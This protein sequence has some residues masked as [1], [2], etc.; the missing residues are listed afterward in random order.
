MMKISNVSKGEVGVI[1][2]IF[3]KQEEL[4]RIDETKYSQALF[5]NILDKRHAKK[6]TEHM[7]RIDKLEQT[8]GNRVINSI[9]RNTTTVFCCWRRD[10]PCMA[11]NSDGPCQRVQTTSQLSV[12]YL[13]PCG[14]PDHFWVWAFLATVLNSIDFHPEVMN[15]L[16]KC[17]L[18][19]EQVGSQSVLH[20]LW[21]PVL[22]LLPGCVSMCACVGTQVWSFRWEVVAGKRGR[23]IFMSG[24]LRF[25]FIF[26]S[27][28]W[29][30]Y[31]FWCL[32]PPDFA[33]IS[34]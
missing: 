34:D 32:R 33:F 1:P 15:L 10:R 4:R 13:E 21:K 31:A 22:L 11:G 25:Y 28:P 19:R 6:A 3:Q 30:T 18:S 24:F 2:L 9:A 12:G 27:F 20:S 29:S 17:V 5:D 7:G 14:I 8:L 26:I 23:S 16:N